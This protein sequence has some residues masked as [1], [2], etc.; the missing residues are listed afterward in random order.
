MPAAQPFCG[1][2]RGSS[3]A[4]AAAMSPANEL[5]AIPTS[6]DESYRICNDNGQCR[7]L[8]T[9]LNVKS[10]RAGKTHRRPRLI[11]CVNTTSDGPLV[12]FAKGSA[13]DIILT[14]EHHL[15]PQNKINDLTAKLRK[16]GYKTCATAAVPSGKSANGTSGGTAV[17]VWDCYTVS[18][19]AGVKDPKDPWTI[20][21]GRCSGAKVHGFVKG[22]ILFLSIYLHSGLK[23]DH[24]DNWQVLTRAAEILT[25]C[26]T[27]YI[28]GGDWQ[29]TPAEL[30]ATGWTATVAGE[31]ASTGAPT[32][33]TAHGE[34]EIDFFVMTPAIRTTC[35]KPAS[36]LDTRIAT[37][38]PIGT[39]HQG[40]ARDG[41]VKA[42]RT[43]KEFPK[44]QVYGPER[45]PPSW[46]P[47][48]NS[49]TGNATDRMNALAR[50][51]VSNTEVEL[52]HRYDLLD[53]Q[54]RPQPEY[55]GRAEKPQLVNTRPLSHPGKTDITAD[56]RG[57]YWGSIL[58]RWTDATRWFTRNADRTMGPGDVCSWKLQRFVDSAIQEWD[59]TNAG[60]KAADQVA[61]QGLSPPPS[62]K[63]AAQMVLFTKSTVKILQNIYKRIRNPPGTV[64]KN[65]ALILEVWNVR[66]TKALDLFEAH[67]KNRFALGTG[68]LMRRWLLDLQSV[69]NGL[70]ADLQKCRNADFKKWLEE[71]LAS[72]A[73]GLHAAT[74]ESFP[75]L[76][77]SIDN[78]E[79]GVHAAQAIAESELSIWA[80]P[81]IWDAVGTAEEN[82]ARSTDHL[83]P[84]LMPPPRAVPS[85]QENR[86]VSRLFSWRT[87]TGG[88]AI[89]PRMIEA[90]SDTAL[91]YLGLLQVN[92]EV[93]G[94]IP[95]IFRLII[96]F[97][98]RKKSGAYRVVGNL[99]TFYRIWTRVRLPIVQ[100]W[101]RDRPSDIFWATA[102]RGAD[103][104][105]HAAAIQCDVA[106][107]KGR[108]AAG[109]QIDVWKCFEV[110]T[111]VT[112]VEQ[113]L[114]SGFPLDILRVAISMYRSERYLVLD[115]AT[116]GP[117]FCAKGVTA[118][119]TLAMAILRSTL[120]PTL[121][122]FYHEVCAPK[123]ITLQV[124]VDDLS[125][126]V[127][128]SLDFVVRNTPYALRILLQRLETLY[129]HAADDKRKL[130]ATA[131]TAALILPKIADLNFTAEPC[132]EQLG[133]D[134]AAGRRSNHRARDKRAN[135]FAARLPKIRHYTRTNKAAG[136]RMATTAG[137]PSMAYGDLVYGTS[138]TRL[139]FQRMI[140]HRTLMSRDSQ[141]SMHLNLQVAG[142][143]VD[144]AYHANSAPILHWAR[145]VRDAGDKL[146]DL[147]AATRFFYIKLRESNSIW[148]SVTGPISGL[149]ATLNRLRWRM[150][151]AHLIRLP[152][153][154]YIDLRII[155]VPKL[156]RMIDAATESYIW[157]KHTCKDPDANATFNNGASSSAVRNLLRKGSALNDEQRIALGSAATGGQ[158][159]AKRH[160]AAEHCED[161]LCLL[162]RSAVG[163]EWHRIHDCT[164][165]TRRMQF[166]TPALRARAATQ[167]CTHHDRWT[168]GHL[169][170]SAYPPVPKQPERTFCQWHNS[171][172]TVFMG[173][174]FLDGSNSNP[175]RADY[176]SNA[177]S[178]VS[179][180]TQNGLP[181]LE[182]MLVVML[183][184]GPDGPEAAE[185][186]AVEHA[187]I[188][189]VLPITAW[190]DCGNVVDSY[191][192]GREHCCSCNH[193]QAVHWRRVFAKV[194]DHGPQ[195]YYD[196]S[197]KKIKAH[198]TEQNY[199]KYG[200]SLLEFRG[201]SW[202][203]KGAKDTALLQAEEM[204]L[205][206]LH[207]EIDELEGEHKSLVRWIAEC[208]ALV[209]GK[210]MRDAVLP[211]ADAGPKP[212][213]V[214][215]AK[216]A[217]KPKKRPRA[218]DGVSRSLGSADPNLEI[219]TV[220]QGGA[221]ARLPMM[222]EG[223]LEEWLEEI[224][225]EERLNQQLPEGQL[226][227]WLTEI[228]N[229]GE[230]EEPQEEK[231]AEEPQPKRQRV[232]RL[233][234]KTSPA[235]AYE[236]GHDDAYDGCI[237]PNAAT[238][239]DNYSYTHG[240]ILLMTGSFIWCVRCG[241]AATVGKVSRYLRESCGGK[242]ANASMRQRRSR[243][244]RGCNPNNSV[245]LNARATRVEVRSIDRS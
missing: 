182:A 147:R 137:A 50:Y 146:P 70:D 105:V 77:D 126:L 125:L 209:N 24:P 152:D 226:E 51:W 95:E 49:A 232:E 244:I 140:Q 37:H 215:R 138:E 245:P 173:Q 63:T 32:C 35:T 188:N 55:L 94:S 66:V 142:K 28:M 36:D 120:L 206:Q 91:R 195:A 129:L 164:L 40:N 174:V 132:V 13:A 84:E 101:E 20:Y 99:T 180:K 183:D 169:P 113:A 111:H 29:C 212:I 80:S 168:R 90:M 150:I 165:E 197:I 203:D 46:Q 11:E 208:T 187:L 115:K 61:E 149:L 88:D 178:V 171:V 34:S 38:Y 191:R 69:S 136:R 228:I 207:K 196:L 14:Q 30:V 236:M 4:G 73:G 214:R 114:L 222:P 75:Q 210:D 123:E 1:A 176:S 107:S 179:M 17:L 67:L 19:I 202:A 234:C 119:C 200:M 139:Q 87:S 128:G 117:V 186:C 135:V 86:A 240:G 45:K 153:D 144:R 161:D 230:G 48:N 233:T 33:T 190:S 23:P 71:Q 109:G 172:T 52:C 163:T 160:H 121:E 162:C 193:P 16:R 238:D 181:A 145:V 118:G 189:C 68:A 231:E 185:V 204:G 224:I 151:G 235:L 21:P 170:R 47:F 44:H 15:L 7:G 241:G 143:Q 131:K 218:P 98:R 159:T 122:D 8:S 3:G 221:Y 82:A 106:V 58:R 175:D 31:V 104:A 155:P 167:R 96:L 92:V 199:M 54:C 194:D 57:T 26:N 10:R 108:T 237:E 89:H 223:Q 133:I 83:W 81:Q 124:F 18:P 72:G 134:F 198:C 130:I 166:L 220:E 22:G 93:V 225:D 158:W 6:F 127:M 74:K 217:A 116:A 205:P 27:P 79:V 100:D 64:A 25:A 239:D 41:H 148:N 9:P 78:I 62:R 59:T 229:E 184:N 110:L 60:T 12:E 242:P 76:P 112:I 216:A 56:V 42:I 65:D 53:E 5:N 2:A 201:N 219:H 39:I 157:R 154:Q 177:C 211:P 192:R 85:I 213:R 97:S 103:V 43:P 156:N 243:L 141:R 227:E 102:G